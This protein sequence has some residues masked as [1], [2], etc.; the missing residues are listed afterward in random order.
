[1]NTELQKSYPGKEKNIFM[2]VTIILEVYWTFVKMQK[3]YFSDCTFSKKEQT[4]NIFPN[5]VTEQ[6]GGSR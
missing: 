4:D 3:M 1:M 5:S 2:S 6:G